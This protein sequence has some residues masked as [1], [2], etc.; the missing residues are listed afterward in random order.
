MKNNN[1]TKIIL[2]EVFVLIVIILLTIL[3]IYGSYLVKSDTIAEI[4]NNLIDLTTTNKDILEKNYNQILILSNIRQ[5]NNEIIA[6]VNK[7]NY[8][9]MPIYGK[10]T[11]DNPNH[12][13]N[14]WFSIKKDSR[15]IP[16][17]NRR[18]LAYDDEIY[19]QKHMNRVSI[20]IL[21]S[22]NKNNISELRF[23]FV[24]F[25]IENLL[26]A[27]IVNKQ[28]L[29]KR[30]E[31]F[32]DIIKNKLFKEYKNI[33]T[34]YDPD[35]ISEIIKNKMSQNY[36]SKERSFLILYIHI[37]YLLF[38]MIV[39]FYLFKLIHNRMNHINVLMRIY[40]KY[41]NKID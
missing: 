4:K 6:F 18:T 1:S 19:Y 12:P 13:K 8:K 20:P 31:V 32:K 2:I 38:I 40:F 17:F 27:K 14:S 26:K 16:Y 15:I 30:R 24:T 9:N 34:S 5:N 29:G 33:T 37:S 11:D 28:S 25:S 3:F 7:M 10:N 41:I 35:N 21:K 39:I 22:I 36:L 23:Y